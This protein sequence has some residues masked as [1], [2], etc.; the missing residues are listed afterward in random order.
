[1]AHA[2]KVSDL[3]DGLVRSVAGDRS[4]HASFRRM[5]DQAAKT[6]RNTTH[7]RTNQ[8][9]VQSKLTGLAEKFAVLNRD[10]LS[11]ALQARLDELPRDS[12]WM[13]E[14]LS[15]LLQLS[16]RPL[17]KTRIENV[18][19]LSKRLEDEQPTLTWEDLVADRDLDESGLWDDVERGHHSSGDEAGVDEEADSDDTSSTRAT[20]VEDDT[21]ALAR[22]HIIHPEESAADDLKDAET[23][24]LSSVS[25][26]MVIRDTLFML[27]GLP[28]KLYVFLES[29]GEVTVHSSVALE[30]AARATTRDLLLQ[31]AEIGSALNTLRHWARQTEKTPYMQ[32]CQAATLSLL[33]EFDRQISTIEQRCV[34]PAQDTVV[35]MMNVRSEVDIA[36][37]ALLHLSQILSASNDSKSAPFSLFDALYSEISIAEMSGDGRVFRSLVQVY[38]SGLKTYLRPLAL[39]IQTGSVDRNN[40]EFMIRE[41]NPDCDLGRFWSERF[42]LRTL[43]DGTVCCPKFMHGMANKIFAIGKGRAFLL[44]LGDDGETESDLQSSAT[45]TICSLQN[46]LAMPQLLPFTQRLEQSL[47]HWIADTSKDGS[48][49]L[50]HKL[51]H[52]SGLLRAIDRLEEVFCS[53]DGVLFQT[54]A[55]TLFG[56]MDYQP[57][58]WRHDFL[59]SELASS[60]FGDRDS[61]GPESLSVTVHEATQSTGSKSSVRQL[62]TIQLQTTFSWSVQNITHVQTSEAHSK[63]FAFLL[64]IYRAKSLLRT[65]ALD[66]K[67]FTSDVRNVAS[68]PHLALLMRQRL[69]S[70]VDIMHDHITNTARI[71]YKTVRIA[72]EAATDIDA[73][74]AVWITHIKHIDM[75]LLLAQKLNPIREAI[76]GCLELCERFA[77]MWPRIAGSQTVTEENAQPLPSRRDF[78]GMRQELDKSVSFIIAGVRSVG[79]ASG[80]KMLEELAERLE[81]MAPT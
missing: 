30:T 12:K 9:D 53:K 67:R 1:M 52:D 35:S 60:T 34:A 39:W 57:N 54:F 21:V 41:A 62:R 66:L 61:M 76:I 74:A 15:L 24:L 14:I 32:S 33:S 59:L 22:L 48:S 43:S 69:I 77:M 10:D 37:K 46:Q 28:T 3:T 38:L 58:G 80:N 50:Q 18:E 70:F 29:D 6:F 73:M 55:D 65:Q 44:A 75:A 5:R 51:L 78:A 56:R 20:T 42:T 26:L 25:E 49:L 11:D 40:T 72:L 47:E 64:Q 68:T 7:A 16:D 2:A 19:V 27:R 23:Q 8:F 71:L 63:A 45:S 79:R 36:A 4:Q 31:F 81:W 13:P 17:E